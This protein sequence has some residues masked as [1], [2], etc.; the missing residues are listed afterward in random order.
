[1]SHST[2]TRSRP[3][4]RRGGVHRRLTSLVLTSVLT[5]TAL[6]DS[7]HAAPNEGDHSWQVREFVLDGDDINVTVDSGRL[8]F[9]PSTTRTDDEHNS[10]SAQGFLVM[11]PWEF[12]E[13][14]NRLSAIPL[15][16]QGR[17]TVEAR[18]LRPAGRWTEW[19]V[20]T[21][22]STDL[23]VSTRTVQTRVVFDDT[24]APASLGGITFHATAGPRPRD[25]D[26]GEPLSYRVFATR[27]GLV[28]GTTANGHRIL[29]RDHFVALPS[30]RGLSA[31]GNGDYTV[32]VCAN[33]RCA[34]APVWDVGPWNTRDNYW[35]AERDQY[36]D[37]RQGLPAAQA[38]FYDGYNGGLDQFKRKVRN[39]SGIDLADGV[40]W[41]GL[42]LTDNS[43]VEATY[44]WTGEGVFAGVKTFGGPLN[45]RREGTVRAPVVGSAANSA[46][47]R[48]ECVV[49]GS[50][51]TGTQG[52][53][54]SW[55]RI[56]PGFFVSAAYVIAPKAPVPP[57]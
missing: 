36:A 11:R 42:G 22:A 3:V 33:S 14:V 37:L 24:Q 30:R 18:A 16:R 2:I 17:V 31:R 29:P 34:W 39:P 7:A 19:M 5:V 44:L 27:E 40:F 28:G 47:V 45:V 54:D 1:M 26:S 4:R 41:D 6:S 21:E 23:G 52:T 8:R 15:D 9:T 10:A 49:T 57:C 48:L 51:A 46:T 35:S 38:A 55:F 50:T 53:S 12:I 25:R 43:W 20:V 13:P 32:R 56:G